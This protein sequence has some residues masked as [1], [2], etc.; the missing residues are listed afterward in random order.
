MPTRLATTPP[1][2]LTEREREVAALVAQGLK[3]R[4]IAA[5]LVVSERTVH[6]HIRNILGKLGLASRAQ[7]ALWVTGGS[8][9]QTSLP[10]GRAAPTRWAP[11]QEPAGRDTSQRN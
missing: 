6:A 1:E 7:V 2:R 10:H 9:S 5:T 8:R 11:Y 4:D 3:N